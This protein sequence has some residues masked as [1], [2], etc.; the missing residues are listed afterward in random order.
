M[1]IKLTEICILIF[2]FLNISKLCIAQGKGV[3]SSEYDRNA[4]T[5]LFLNGNDKYSNQL[6]RAMDSLNVPEKFFDNTLTKRAIPLVVNRAEIART[7]SYKQEAPKSAV[8]A[9]MKNSGIGREIIAKWF[10]RKPDGSFGVKILSQ[11]GIYNANDNELLVA[12]ASKRGT[13][14]LMDMGMSLVNKSYVMLIDVPELLTM[15]EIYQRDTVPPAKQTMNGFQG[16]MNIYVY[17]L[18][19][20]EA[21]AANFFENLWISE[22]SS[23]KAERQSKFDNTD[24]RLLYIN[25]FNESG[26][27][28]QLNPDQKFAPKQKSPEQLLK[29]LLEA[30]VNQALFKLEKAESS[31]KV[32]AMI[33]DMHP[34]AVKIGRKEG[35]KFDQ[36]FF[37]Y[38]NL[39]NRKGEVYSK[40]RGVIR[41]KSVSNNLK[42][43][44]GKTEPSYFYQVAG[45]KLDNMGMFIEQANAYGLNL[46]LGYTDGALGGPTGKFEI[47]ISPLLYEV[48]GKKGK[49]SRMTGTKIYIELAG[50]KQDFL[51]NSGSLNTGF[52]RY[53]GGLSKE[54]R[55]TKNSFLEPHI[56]YGMEEATWKD[57]P[58]EK[59]ESQFLEYGIGLGLNLKHNVQLIPSANFFSII[60]SRYKETK[61]DET[62]EKITYSEWF[63]GRD[64]MGFG[65]GLRFMF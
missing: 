45:R 33:T 40:R 24:F 37:V 21:V 49:I 65:I 58:G 9:A 43:T 53:S 59:V 11:R 57:Y 30:G 20:S 26:A 64:G 46:Y 52:I 55:L 28:T 56:G 23:N 6:V 36:R 62:P 8:D 10:D 1:K 38:E 39:Q 19:F 13:A 54:M 34:I 25:T 32:K 42:A 27:A 3:V 51:T 15:A 7:D 50:Q 2:L 60:T 63:P 12:N 44:D 61:E 22:N 4:L 14:G 29:T 31:F 41:A 5:I 48:S 17:K 16:K 35:L 18:D 47:L